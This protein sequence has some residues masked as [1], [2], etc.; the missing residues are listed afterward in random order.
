VEPGLRTGCFGIDA[1]ASWLATGSNDV[2]A[3][4]RR[5]KVARKSRPGH[6]F[7]VGSSAYR[8]A[9]TLAPSS[10]DPRPEA[11]LHPGPDSFNSQLG[12]RSAAADSSLRMKS[13]RPSGKPMAAPM[14][15]APSA[16]AEDIED[17][18]S[19]IALERG[20]SRNT[21]VSYRNDLV[22]AAHFLKK[23][24][25]RGWRVVTVKHLTAWLHWLSDSKF[26]ASTQARKLTAVRML[27]RHLVREQRRKD[28]PTELLPGPK[29]RR[30][31]PQTLSTSEMERLLEAPSGGDAYALRDRAMLELF[32]SSGLRISELCGLTIQQADLE[33]G[34]VRVFGKGAKER[35]VPLGG[36]ACESLQS[37]LTS[38]RA[39]L[40]KPRTGSELFLSERGKAI[41][42]KTLW[43]IVKKYAAKA[44][45]PASVKPHLLRHSFATHLLEGGADLRTVQ[46]MLGHA[47]IVTTE[48]YTHVD[49][50]YLK[51]VHRSFHPRYAAPVKE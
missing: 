24:C 36:K 37:Y 14:A 33:H 35:I 19:T 44:G 5:E 28:N 11:A 34:F 16:F 7:A 20:L 15:P 18:L 21:E 47:N 46:E 22:Q 45:L 4:E 51:E 38:G 29:F 42:R 13:P 3:F 6:A 49:R 10:Y 41:S 9:G 50:E 39:R 48:I 30:K 27:C 1:G 31:L 25:P 26:T 17:Y 40:V 2:A 43:V 23:A 32:Y 8:V 12:S